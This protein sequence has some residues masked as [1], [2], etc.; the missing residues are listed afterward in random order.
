MATQENQETELVPFTT[1]LTRKNR[2]LLKKL[3]AYE[4]SDIEKVTNRLFDLFFDAIGE[5][6]EKKSFLDAWPGPKPKP[7]R[8]K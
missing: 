6:P 1:R 3:V 7:A 2:D 5:I 4:G 8:K